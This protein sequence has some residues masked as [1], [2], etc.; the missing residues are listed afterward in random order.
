MRRVGGV[1]VALLGCL[2]G[3]MAPLAGQIPSAA[4]EVWLRSSAEELLSI[5]YPQRYGADPDA[6]AELTEALK[7]T[8][9][10]VREIRRLLETGKREGNGDA[11]IA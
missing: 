3:W 4:P 10:E 2:L 9:G 1:V 8:V 6:L 7:A 5:A 11:P